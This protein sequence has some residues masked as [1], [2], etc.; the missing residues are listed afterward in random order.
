M[1][2]FFDDIQATVRSEMFEAASPFERRAIVENMLTS[3]APMKIRQQFLDMQQNNPTKAIGQVNRIL[4]EA[5]APTEGEQQQQFIETAAPIAGG[6][7]GGL[8]MTP[9]IGGQVIGVT[10]GT[11]AGRLFPEITRDYLTGQPGQFKEA[12]KRSVQS[13][14]IETPPLVFLSEKLLRGTGK[15]VG[16]VRSAFSAVSKEPTLRAGTKA[17]RSVIESGR[18]ASGLSRSTQTGG[19][20]IGQQA[21]QGGILQAAESLFEGSFGGRRA[22]QRLARDNEINTDAFVDSLVARYAPTRTASELGTAFESVVQSGKNSTYKVAKNISHRLHQKV[23]KAAQGLNVSF[24]DTVE[25]IQKNNR[26]PAMQKVFKAFTTQVEGT[27]KNANRLFGGR[28]GLETLLGVTNDP[29]LIKQLPAVS[30]FTNADIAQSAVG[31]TIRELERQ[32]ELGAASLAK[33]LFAKIRTDM[34]L[35]ATKFGDGSVATL[36]K[37]AKDFARVEVFEKFNNRLILDLMEEMRVRPGVL[38]ARLLGEGST[39]LLQAVKRVTPNAEF[40]EIRN[41]LMATLLNRAKDPVAGNFSGVSKVSGRTLMAQIHKLEE[42][43]SGY[44]KVLLGD[45]KSSPGLHDFQRIA[46]AVETYTKK[47]GSDAGIFIKFAQASALGALGT[48]F[49]TGHVDQPMTLLGSGAILIAP[50]YGARLFTNRQAIR[51][52]ADGLIGG[53]K[54]EAM[55][56]VLIAASAAHQQENEKIVGRVGANKQVIL[57]TINA[58]NQARTTPALGP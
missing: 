8:A 1:G 53:P 35:A 42:A 27:G 9:T 50:W 36:Y 44:M 11:M 55:K 45:A 56:R 24:D 58:G 43:N 18:A 17:A 32:G 20:S 25:F 47:L 40:N 2:Q 49:I 6:V 12:F 57:D 22:F 26:N 15:L 23:D 14:L 41:S 38:T 7:I 33:T 28:R 4:K 30:S 37:E 51:N 10:A 52:F 19:L 39:D 13:D 16:G 48:A 54:S 5:G 34:D 46:N 29:G 31:S 3:Q 21:P